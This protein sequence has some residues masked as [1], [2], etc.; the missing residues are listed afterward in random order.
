M[1]GRTFGPRPEPGEQRPD[2]RRPA[3]FGPPPAPFAP[4]TPITP[5]TPA[6]PTTPAA[7]HSGGR[8]RLPRPVAAVGALAAL[9]AALLLIGGGAY[10][11]TVRGE[12]AQPLAGP[13]GSPSVDQGDGKGPGGGPDAY[14]PNSGI[15][16]GEAR[17]WLRD[18]RAE[19]PGA[20]TSQYGPWRVGDTVVGAIP[21]GLTAYA[22]AD[23]QEKWTLPLQTPLCGVP[24]APSADGKLVVGLKESASETSHCTQ[25]QQIDLTTGRAGWK[26]PLPP[27]NKYDSALQ[28]EL[29]ISGDTV[30]VARSAVM[31]GFSVADGHKLFGTSSPNGCY[32]YGFAG[33]S[34]LI[35]LRQCPDPKDAVARGQAMVEEL[36]PATGGARWSYKYAQDWTVGRVLSVDPLVITAHHKDKKTWN[37]TAFAADGTVRSQSSPAFGVSGRCNGFGHA[38]G[39]QECYAAAADADTLYIGAGPPGATLDTDV[40]D[41]VVAV[42]LNTG[43]ERWRTAGQP[44]GRTMWPLAVEE[45]RVVTYVTPGSGRAASVVS[46][47]AA[48][49][50]SQ[51]VLQSP[52]AASGAEDVF[53]PHGIR[54]AWTG[55]RL[56]LL[57]GRVYSPEPRKVSRAILS[58]G[59]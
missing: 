23:G 30:A 20:G 31:S 38:D 13:S 34:R 57:N 21:T 58:F 32:P 10:R 22:V 4:H 49:G 55:G 1:T 29:A 2:D 5:I 45:G 15:Q 52:A 16:A 46:L 25:L 26:I 17:V 19:V 7:P 54:I 36:D 27:E 42:D 24:R 37:V 8:S 48:D 59:K 41:Q 53:Y 33:G 6:A 3:G 44:K 9:L 12:P 28:F 35:G 40:T 14:D 39:F 11:L 18:N 43:K 50:A 51:P 56:F 47:A